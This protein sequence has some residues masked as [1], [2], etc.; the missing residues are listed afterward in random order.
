MPSLDERSGFYLHLD[1]SQRLQIKSCPLIPNTV[2][3]DPERPSHQILGKASTGHIAHKV[4]YA[5]PPEVEEINAKINRSF[6]QPLS[7]CLACDLELAQRV[8]HSGFL[9]SIASLTHEKRQCAEV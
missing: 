3:C 6:M 4:G 9:F 8:R 2:C 5:P 1:A 7:T